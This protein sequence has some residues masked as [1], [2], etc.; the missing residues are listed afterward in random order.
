M[1]EKT[2][3]LWSDDDKILVKD[4]PGKALKKYVS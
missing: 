3:Y 2:R 1:E 4:E